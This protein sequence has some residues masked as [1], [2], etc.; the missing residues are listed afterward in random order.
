M[1]GRYPKTLPFIMKMMNRADVSAIATKHLITVISDEFF[2]L[3]DRRTMSETLFVLSNLYN[4]IA[5]NGI[6]IEPHLCNTI[7]TVIVRILDTIARETVQDDV[8]IINIEA[9][10]CNL[11]R[12]ERDVRA[13]GVLTDDHFDA[14]SN[15]MI[16][17]KWSIFVDHEPSSGR[18]NVPCEHVVRYLCSL[19][20]TI[21]K[22]KDECVDFSHT[23]ILKC[24]IGI[25]YTLLKT[26]D[27]TIPAD[28]LTFI[29]AQVD[30]AN[31]SF[32]ITIWLEIMMT[33]TVDPVGETLFWCHNPACK[34]LAGDHELK[35]PTSSDGMG[36]RFCC[37]ECQVAEWK[38][39][40]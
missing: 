5:T 32:L 18:N 15:N 22:V 24:I 2:V 40:K 37:R 4:K 33:M 35:L 11:L 20:R 17:L 14:I 34:N 1:H 25:V 13:T 36:K 28:P 8:R 21:S 30:E 3:D 19:F 39:C 38:R 16:I 10:W 23:G 9:S 7:P 26:T 29:K 6:T 27:N 12:I 31:D